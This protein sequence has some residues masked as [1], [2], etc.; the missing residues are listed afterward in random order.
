MIQDCRRKLVEAYPAQVREALAGFAGLV[1]DGEGGRGGLEKTAIGLHGLDMGLRQQ[2]GQA[3][4][5]VCLKVI[6]GNKKGAHR[7]QQT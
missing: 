7:L 6:A 1:C 2:Y 5:G 4:R 3:D